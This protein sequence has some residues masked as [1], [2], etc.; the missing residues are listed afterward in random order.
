MAQFAIPW[1]FEYRVLARLQV[2]VLLSA[3]SLACAC[4]KS[5]KAPGEN[6]ANGSSTPAEDASQ[7]SS[8][9]TGP[10]STDIQAAAAL[11]LGSNAEVL[12]FGNLARNGHAQALVVNRALTSQS[13][14][15]EAAPSGTQVVPFTRASVIERDGTRWIEVL[16][17]DEHLTNSKGFLAGAPLAP[18]TGWLV[19]WSQQEDGSVQAMYFTPGRAPGEVS[20]APIAVRWNPSVKRYQSVDRTNNQFLS[21]LALLETPTSILK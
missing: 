10:V 11:L 14:A 7:T 20:P 21:E 3:V 2:F 6:Q 1:L 16:R 8:S 13:R 18:V 15:G 4:G 12:A 5:G 17:C 19:Q 9:R